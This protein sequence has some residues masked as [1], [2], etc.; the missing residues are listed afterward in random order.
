MYKA[1]Q[2]TA[3]QQ[4]NPGAGASSSSSSST[5]SNDAE[6]TDVDFEEVK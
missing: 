1:S 2:E 6:V 5:G 4:A 3:G